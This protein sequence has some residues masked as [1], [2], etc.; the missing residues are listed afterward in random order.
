MMNGLS[1]LY[2][3]AGEALLLLLL[4]DRRE[5]GVLHG[6]TTL[7]LLPLAAV[8]DRHPGRVV[9]VVSV[10]SPVVPRGAEDIGPVVLDPDDRPGDGRTGDV[11]GRKLQQRIGEDPSREESRLP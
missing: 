11:L 8:D 4:Q 10:R 7:E 3:S 5:C 9:G 2:S 6:L 1:I